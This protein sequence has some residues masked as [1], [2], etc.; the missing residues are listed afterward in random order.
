MTW[1]AFHAAFNTNPVREQLLKGMR[2]MLAD[3]H[4]AGCRRVW[5]DGSFVTTKDRP[6]DFD[7]CW[8]AA[9]VDL[10]RLPSALLT[11]DQKRAAQKAKYGGEAFPA[12]AS[13]DGAGTLFIDFFQVD[14]RT[15]GLK[16]IVCLDLNEVFSK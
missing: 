1:S 15:G 16:G 4:A 12:S 11:F 7:L 13:A 6:N 14:K 2:A 3:L 5:I 10:S 9:G 8:D